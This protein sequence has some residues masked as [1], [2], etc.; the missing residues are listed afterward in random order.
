VEP[1][2]E[3]A[4]RIAAYVA[5]Q[6][7]PEQRD[8]VTRAVCMTV[9]TLMADPA[10]TEEL[11]VVKTLRAENKWLKD[12]YL[13]LKAMMAQV[14]VKPVRKRA[15]SGSK[16]AASPKRPAGSSSGSRAKKQAA[17]PRPQ[18][19]NSSFRQGFDEMRG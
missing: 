18:A 17:R 11:V 5:T 8:V 15:T 2:D 1:Q 16:R 13:I 9:A 19:P 3:L 14:G 12:N 4:R 7:P 6:V 10:F